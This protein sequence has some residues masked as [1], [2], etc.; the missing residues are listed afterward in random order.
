ME[1]EGSFNL[2]RTTLKGKEN[3]K[4]RFVVQLSMT[5]RDVVE[6]ARRIAGGM[7]TIITHMPKGGRKPVWI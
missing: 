5:D 6:S 7:G 4:L 2:A 3:G 1:G